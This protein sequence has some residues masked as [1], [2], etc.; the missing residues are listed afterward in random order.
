MKRFILGFTGVLLS[1]GLLGC[2]SN[3]PGPGPG[4]AGTTGGP[5]GVTEAEWP[6]FTLAWSEYP[7]WSVFG[8]AHAKKLI[9][10]AEG[11]RSELELKWNVDIVL[12]QL[13]YD[14]CITQYGSGLADAVCIT[15][16]D[17]LSPSLGR[18]SV[19]ICPTS[20]SAGA[21]ACIVLGI[22]DVKALREHKVYG[23]DKSVSE[24]CF[25]RNLELLGEDEKAHK[26]TSKGP[27]EAALAMQSNPEATKAIMVWNPF[28]MQT[29]RKVPGSKRLFDSSTIPGE[30]VDMLVMSK[31]SLDKPGGKEFACAIIDTFYHVS[32]LIDAP[33]TR[34]DT[35]L[36]LAAKFAPELTVADM[37]Q[38]VT[39]TAFYKTPDAGMELYSSD[40][41]KETMKKVLAFCTSHGMI[42]KEPGEAQLKF[43]TSYMQMVKEKP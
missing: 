37:E 7:S 18:A 19:A 22:D 5:T 4:G 42:D 9:N 34:N 28:V 6:V 15:N 38:V 3:K 21:D 26:F 12:K 43:D 13:T 16:M 2:N 25:V 30:I 36:A 11:Q 14:A 40:E 29:L 23:L 1:F 31:E 20:T 33:E 27:D 17:I 8:V 41:F 39:E 24:Y 35:L 32:N 10:G